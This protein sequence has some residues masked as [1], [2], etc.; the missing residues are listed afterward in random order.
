[1]A[2]AG[3]DISAQKSKGVKEFLAKLF[4]AHLI[5]LCKD[6]ETRCPTCWPG[7][8]NRMVW[9][10]DNPASCQGTE[11]ERLAAFR[12]VRDQIEAKILTWLQSLPP[13]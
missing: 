8:V 5:V 2:E 11:E 9:P 13:T 10:F 3:I 4:V 7:P 6:A 12:T 1:M